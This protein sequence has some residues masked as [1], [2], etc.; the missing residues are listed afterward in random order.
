MTKDMLWPPDRKVWV[1]FFILTLFISGSLFSSF[2]PTLLPG[3]DPGNPDS[4]PDSI[5]N[6]VMISSHA[7]EMMLAGTV[8]ILVILILLFFKSVLSFVFVDVIV[9]RKTG[10]VSRFWSHLGRGLQYFGIYLLALIFAVLIIFLSAFFILV[11]ALI[12]NQGQFLSILDTFF[13]YFMVSLLCLFP[14]WVFLIGMYD[15]IVPVMITDNCSIIFAYKTVFSLLMVNKKRIFWYLLIR[16]TG[17]LAVA[18]FIFF[19]SLFLVSLFSS[20]FSFF[21]I[22]GLFY[23]FC[24]MGSLIFLSVLILT[25]ATTFFRLF[26][27]LFLSSLD[28]RYGRSVSPGMPGIQE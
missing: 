15:F 16:V 26:S 1:R 6:P 18:G 27:L 23:A 25:P 9:D 22:P 8:I 11:P 2:D 19:F 7:E 5:T 4:L 3:Y 10:I 12:E 13:T 17:A 21:S 14:V 24:S 20:L 28:P